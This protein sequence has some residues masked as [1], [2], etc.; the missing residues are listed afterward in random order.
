MAETLIRFILY[1]GV[2]ALSPATAISQNWQDIVPLHSSKV[3]VERILGA[4]PSSGKYV[5]SYE[6][7]NEFI[8]VAYA[9]GPPCGRTLVDS[10]RV[11]RDTVVNVRVISKRSVPLKQV[12]PDPSGYKKVVEPR[13]KNTL[14]YINEEKGLRY[15]VERREDNSEDVISTDYLPQGKDRSMKCSASVSARDEIPIFERYGNISLSTEKAILDN[16][17]I[18]LQRNTQLKGYVV[19]YV[20]QAKKAPVKIRYIMNYLIG[21]RAVPRQRVTAINGGQISEAGVELYLVPHGKP[22]PKLKQRR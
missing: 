10:W 14:Y 5:S 22:G 15:T 13:H 17:A 12:L 8:D 20:D 1:L 18:Q 16:F 9:S 6:S 2:L 3:D 21:E 19:V 4:P 7:E 11:P